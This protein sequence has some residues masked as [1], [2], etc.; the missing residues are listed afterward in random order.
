MTGNP[1]PRGVK[2]EMGPNGTDADHR[3]WKQCVWKKDDTRDIGL[4]QVRT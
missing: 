2:G 1:G 4:L 3:N